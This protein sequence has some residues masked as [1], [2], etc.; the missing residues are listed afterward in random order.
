[1]RKEI[2]KGM[3]ILDK[4]QEGKISTKSWMEYI[5]KAEKEYLNLYKKAFQIMKRL[6][7]RERDLNEALG[8]VDKDAEIPLRIDFT[9]NET[10]DVNKLMGVTDTS[11]REIISDKE[12]EI[13]TSIFAKN[14]MINVPRFSGKMIDWLPFWESYKQYIHQTNL[15]NLVKFNALRDCLEGKAAALIKRYPQDGSFYEE[16]IDRLMSIYNNSDN[17]TRNLYDKLKGIKRARESLNEIRRTFNEVAVILNQLKRL[18]NDVNTPGY[19]IEARFKFPKSVLEELAKEER[20]NYEGRITNMDDLLNEIENHILIQESI[21]D[22]E[23]QEVERTYQAREN[24]NIDCG[25]C[26]KMGHRA[27]VFH[28]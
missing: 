26:G 6:W 11:A 7:N 16:A 15:S 28:N 3:I 2:D 10:V 18:G 17:Q 9:L 13:M 4:M 12:Q 25:L 19:L 24:R 8:R 27:R 22:E 1:M 14:K 20:A 23:T 5:D 21:E